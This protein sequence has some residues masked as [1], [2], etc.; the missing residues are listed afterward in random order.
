[1][2]C[3]NSIDVRTKIRIARSEAPPPANAK[4][5][6][7][8]FSILQWNCLYSE[9][10]AEI[11]EF[12]ATHNPDILCL[13]E[14]TKNYHH[15]DGETG[16]QLAEALG[17]FEFCAYGP[18]ALPDGTQALMGNGIFSRHP[19]TRTSN[20][21]IQSGLVVDDKITVDERYYLEADTIIGDQKITIG[22]THLPFHP[23]SKTTPR[24]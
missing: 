12:I 3:T 8:K 4:L 11:G 17:Y 21:V 18:M 16:T 9:D 22:T 13:Q 14:L 5:K 20:H 10:I 24:K 7:M 19:F 23:E 6:S 2:V 15:K 1:M